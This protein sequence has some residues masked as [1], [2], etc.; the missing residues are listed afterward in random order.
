MTEFIIKNY[1][2][3]G[4][5]ERKKAGM[6][7]SFLGVFLNLLLFSLKYLAGV[8]S[9][10]IAITADG[11]NNLADAGACVLSVLGFR[12][13]SKKRTDK[14]PLGY[15]KLEYISGLL[16]SFIVIWIGVD[17]LCSSIE[18][19]AH[20][21]DVC[22]SPAVIIILILSI[23]IKVWMYR[24]S[25]KLARM[26]GSSGV[27]ATAVDSL[28]D[29]IATAAILI[30][31]IIEE[32]AGINTDGYTGVLVAFCI[33]YAGLSSVKESITPLLCNG[34]STQTL[35]SLAD[36]LSEYGVSG[37]CEAAVHDC[38]PEKKLLTFYIRCSQPE[39]VI[40][41]I[42]RRIR[43]ELDMEAFISLTE[44]CENK[45]NKKDARVQK[46]I[47]EPKT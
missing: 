39:L 19:I 13:G 4:R 23:L 5:N 2:S 9:G 33:I 10:S 42:K 34:L 17:M 20:P 24:S 43:D 15:G 16:I 37:F 44:Q 36:I 40:P 22:G 46:Y 8:M 27:R 29:C 26:I 3:N 28:C 31:V 7:L 47:Q 30:S 35:D 41:A 38:G 18:K 45:K 21:A 11:F 12:L 32:T 25:N 6:L 14:F 1:L